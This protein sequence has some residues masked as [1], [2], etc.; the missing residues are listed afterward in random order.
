MKKTFPL[1]LTFAFL[2]PC[3]FLSN[4]VDA[5]CCCGGG[6]DDKTSG[7][8]HAGLL[9]NQHPPAGTGYGTL[10]QQD[11]DTSCSSINGG[12]KSLFL[13]DEISPSKL[14]RRSK[15]TVNS[16]VLRLEMSPSPRRT[17]LGL[18]GDGDADAGIVR[19][20]VSFDRAFSGTSPV[21]K[22]STVTE[23]PQV[24]PAQHLMDRIMKSPFGSGS[25]KSDVLTATH[26]E[27]LETD[28]RART[29]VVAVAA[30]APA[31]ASVTPPRVR[32]GTSDS[33]FK[34]S[35]GRPDAVGSVVGSETLAARKAAERAERTSSSGSEDSHHSG[36]S[37]P[38]SLEG[39]EAENN[40]DDEAFPRT[41]VPE[42]A[43]SRGAG[44]DDDE[45]TENE[46][47][48]QGPSAL[49]QFKNKLRGVLNIL[50]IGEASSSGGG[51]GSSSRPVEINFSALSV[52]FLARLAR[53]FWQD[54]NTF[55][56]SLIGMMGLGDNPYDGRLC[57]ILSYPSNAAW[58]LLN[59]N[60]ADNEFVPPAEGILTVRILKNTSEGWKSKEAYKLTRHKTKTLSELAVESIFAEDGP[61]DARDP[62]PAFFGET[63]EEDES[64]VLSATK[65]SA[66]ESLKKYLLD[67]EPRPFI[68]SLEKAQ[69]A[70]F[71]FERAVYEMITGI[72]RESL[73]LLAIEGDWAGSVP[74]KFDSLRAEYF[75]VRTS[76]A[77]EG[78]SDEPSKL[79]T[80]T[81]TPSSD[82]TSVDGGSRRGS[83]VGGKSRMTTGTFMKAINENPTVAGKVRYSASHRG[84]TEREA[85]DAHQLYEDW[86]S[87]ISS[88]VTR[89]VDDSYSVQ[90]LNDGE[91]ESIQAA[92]SAVASHPIGIFFFYEI[93]QNIYE[94]YPILRPYLEVAGVR[95]SDETATV[96]L[97]KGETKD[98]QN[99]LSIK[100]AA[101]KNYNFLQGV[102]PR[103]VVEALKKAGAINADLTKAYTKT[104]AS[105]RDPMDAVGVG[106]AAARK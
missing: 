44:E 90:E 72:W 63:I 57:N 100:I 37:S 71:F 10:A 81:P 50:G 55:A 64:L 74:G 1:V 66:R 4:V 47:V 101:S 97:G 21:Q 26:E 73:G 19:V 35:P 28:Q 5:C 31:P 48:L 20:L 52:D 15:E 69:P 87:F 75:I 9:E 2:I 54:P 60:N 8:V 86:T 49:E 105:R 53:E 6:D 33:A 25:P 70:D 17:S 24:A 7:S 30:P 89:R 18:E 68:I 16:S 91:I 59:D 102:L 36:I 103:N 43:L 76:T 95:V 88:Y 65:Q 56:T 32:M 67:S 106:V 27:V 104:T 84:F 82:S 11:M 13:R 40:E 83:T 41:S 38:E 42:D 92:A 45:G 93:L 85:F 22:V 62:T 3:L 51:G 29:P 58:L 94:L 96:P 99:I 79:I 80:P 98:V 46:A 39:G 61:V 34:P 14:P 23:V 78:E 12:E 77:D